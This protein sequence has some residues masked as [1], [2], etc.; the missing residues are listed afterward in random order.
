MSDVVCANRQPYSPPTD[1]APVLPSTT[2]MNAHFSP[3][4]PTL[5]AATVAPPPLRLLQRWAPPAPP[6][7]APPPRGWAA[8]AA[9]LRRLIF[10]R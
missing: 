2:A 4:L 3:R 7:P 1:R 5:H 9:A 8:V 6:R 10:A